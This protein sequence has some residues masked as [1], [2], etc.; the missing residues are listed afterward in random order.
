MEIITL[1]SLVFLLS[2]VPLY[3]PGYLLNFVQFSSTGVLI[4]GHK[5]R[6]KRK[7]Y[8]AP[9]SSWG[10]PRKFQLKSSHY[11]VALSPFLHRLS[12]D[13]F[14]IDFGISYPTGVALWHF[15]E[16]GGGLPSVCSNKGRWGQLLP[17]VILSNIFGWTCEVD[18]S[19]VFPLLPVRE[20]WFL[21][22][23]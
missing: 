19:R 20:V 5:E 15:R 23:V 9:N 3:F 1:I 2:P 11:R 14:C 21:L 16:D 4:L 10:R 18:L 6:C 12:S 8:L 7:S 17:S 13:P 22:G